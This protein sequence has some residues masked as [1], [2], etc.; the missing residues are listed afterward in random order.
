MAID[1]VK[2]ALPSLSRESLKLL[3][4]WIWELI[5]TG[6]RRE[7][8]DQ[9]ASGIAEQSQLGEGATGVEVAEAS[10]PP[11]EVKTS[12]PD[13]VCCKIVNRASQVAIGQCLVCEG[14]RPPRL[15]PR[16]WYDSE[17]ALRDYKPW[18]I[19]EARENLWK[20]VAGLCAP[21]S[22]AAC[23]TPPPVMDHHLNS[24]TFSE[25][26]IAKAWVIEKAKEW[27]QWEAKGLTSD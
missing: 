6:A 21:H 2:A 18:V 1:A 20:T 8:L 12:R 26:Q 17:E 10:R 16:A 15:K 24:K 25:R 3:H 14:K 11:T 19:K 4:S 23:R 27:P 9:Q 7:L 22:W 5:D 13:K